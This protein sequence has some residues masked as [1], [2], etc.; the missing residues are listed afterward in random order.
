MAKKSSSAQI[1]EILERLLPKEFTQGGESFRKQVADT[2]KEAAERQMEAL[3]LYEPQPLQEQY[4]ACRAKECVMLK[5]NRTGGTLAA[6][7]EVARA[8]TGQDPYDKYPK[9]DGICAVIGYGESH[10]G[11]VFHK[12]LLEPGA[13]DIIKDLDTNMWRAYRPWPADKLIYGKPGDLHRKKERKPAPPLIPK[14]FVKTVAWVKARQKIF[15]QIYLTTGWR[16]D[17]CNSAGDPKQYQGGNV[18][19]VQM[20]EDTQAPGWYTELVGRTSGVEGLLRWTALPHMKNNEMSNL[21]ERAEDDKTG[22]SVV[23]SAGI[24]DNKF[25]EDKSREESVAIWRAM[26]EEEYQ[27]RAFGKVVLESRLMYP[28]FSRMVHEAIKESTPRLRVQEIMAEHRGEPPSDWCRYAAIDPGHSICAVVF[29]GVPPPALGDHVVAYDELYLTNCTA[30]LLGRQM[31]FKVSNW[32]FQKFIIDAQGGRVADMAT[33][34]QPMKQY[35]R[36]FAVNGVTSIDTGSGFHVGSTDIEGRV[37]MLRTWLSVREDGTS[38]L[39]FCSAR[40]PNLVKE[41]ERFRKKIVTVHGE[42][43]PIDEGERRRT[44]AV[45]CLEYLAAYGCPYVKPPSNCARKTWIDMIL[46]RRKERSEAW[47]QRHG[48]GRPSIS[49]GPT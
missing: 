41:I 20:D 8:V 47:N 16:I 22:Q 13:F 3:R 33:G 34:I 45:E 46:E 5:G 31:K 28:T 9:T 49:L 27:R 35:E 44:H 48:S 6:C 21:L 1:K 32:L 38:K 36:E 18:H 42:A 11:R 10:L 30:E 14:R 39:L 37:G 25:I 2:A 43:V 4:H 24:Y 29:L 40:T 26:G 15:S 17:G 23:I 12:Y 19:L 7:V